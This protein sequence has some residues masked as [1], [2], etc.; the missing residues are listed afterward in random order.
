MK[1]YL[2]S[3]VQLEELTTEKDI[4]KLFQKENVLQKN[5]DRQVFKKILRVVGRNDLAVKL[6]RGKSK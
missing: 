5:R 4:E 3:A 6:V 2:F 1:N